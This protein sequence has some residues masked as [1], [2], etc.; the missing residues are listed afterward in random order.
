MKAKLPNPKLVELTD[1]QME[2]LAPFFDVIAELDEAGTP[3]M[4]VAQV[5][6]LKMRV[7]IVPH[8]RALKIQEIMG[9]EVGATL[10]GRSLR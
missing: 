9:G 4:F 6:A 8:D 2:Q 5:F 10:R 3:G 1:E 7:G